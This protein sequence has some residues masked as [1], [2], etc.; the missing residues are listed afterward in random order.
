DRLRG[1]SRCDDCFPGAAVPGRRPLRSTGIE[2][3]HR[4]QTDAMLR[5]GPEDQ[6]SLA[7]DISSVLLRRTGNGRTTK[8]GKNRR[9]PDQPTS[10]FRV[11]RVFRGLFSGA[12]AQSFSF[13][14]RFVSPAR[15]SRIVYLRLCS[16]ELPAWRMTSTNT[17]VSAALPGTFLLR[18]TS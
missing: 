16:C 1:L 12:V 14:T 2:R 10:S 9:T 3:E 11:F 13:A 7:F 4:R 5:V 17:H 18:R 8:A 15:R 6:A